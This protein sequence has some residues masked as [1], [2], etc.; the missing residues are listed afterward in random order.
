VK[1]HPNSWHSTHDGIH[2]RTGC[3]FAE[4]GQNRC[5]PLW[6]ITVLS[7]NRVPRQSISRA[8]NIYKKLCIRTL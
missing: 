6:L 3:F 8:A 1:C 2:S 7:P 5:L 4:S